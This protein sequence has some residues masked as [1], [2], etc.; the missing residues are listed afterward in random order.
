M[1]NS[2][3]KQG[4]AYTIAALVAYIADMAVYS[5]LVT[6]LATSI[7]IATFFG[8]IINSLIVFFALTGLVF[9]T[10]KNQWKKTAGRYTLACIFGFVL[11]VA[12]TM[13]V[14]HFFPLIH[15]ILAR[16]IGSVM[17]FFINFLIIRRFVY[18]Q[19]SHPKKSR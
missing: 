4:A 19:K 5:L 12:F 18:N 9:K 15:K 6:K 2:M 8:Y 14:K 17:A 3:Y 7:P 16:V 1:S 13:G 11:N 10:E